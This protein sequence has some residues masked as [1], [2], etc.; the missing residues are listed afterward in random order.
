MGKKVPDALKKA[1]FKYIEKPDE[2]IMENL[3]KSCFPDKNVYN[4]SKRNNLPK[5]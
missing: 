4:K 2:E 5:K 1:L 3:L